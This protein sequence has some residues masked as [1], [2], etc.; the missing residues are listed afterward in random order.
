MK[1]TQN[2]NP[3]QHSKYKHGSITKNPFLLQVD[4][5]N[6]RTNNDS[7]RKFIFDNFLKAPDKNW[8]GLAIGSFMLYD[9]RKAQ[10]FK[11]VGLTFFF[12]F[13]SCFFLI[14]LK[15]KMIRKANFYSK[16]QNRISN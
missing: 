13:F 5:I 7:L 15:K 16:M 9:N 4:R 2:E 3:N 8:E 11:L 1:T 14:F 10:E 12:F 6:P